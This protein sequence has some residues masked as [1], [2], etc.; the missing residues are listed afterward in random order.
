[1]SKK[2]AFVSH[3]PTLNFACTHLERSVLVPVN[4]YIVVIAISRSSGEV[5]VTGT[6]KPVCR[7]CSRLVL[8]STE[9]QSCL[10]VGPTRIRR[11]PDVQ[12]TMEN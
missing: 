7:F 9:G 8:T 2:S 12:C 3:V 1:V 6:E 5:K 4:R 10:V 11:F